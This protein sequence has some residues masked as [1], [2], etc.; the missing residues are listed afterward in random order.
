MMKLT[1]SLLATLA[2]AFAVPHAAHADDDDQPMQPDYD[3]ASPQ[4]ASPPT[5][6]PTEMPPVPPQ[7]L[8]P[9]PSAQDNAD[10]QD[11]GYEQPQQ[12]V[13]IEQAQSSGQWVYTA[14]YGWVW[15]PYGNQYVSAQSGDYDDAYSYV[16]YPGN[17]WIWLASP[18]IGGWGPWPYFGHYGYGHYGWWHRP[19]FAFHGGYGGYHGHFGNGYGRGGGHVGYG[20]VGGGVRVGGGV[21]RPS[22][23]G[24]HT[25]FATGQ[26]GVSRPSYS[27]PRSIGTV[28]GGASIS[29]SVGVSH[30]APVTHA[31]GGGSF[32]GGGGGGGHGGGGHGGRR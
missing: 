24:P 32:H 13:A 26:R 21:S 11:D 8:P 12:P 28:R 16:Y 27:G 20:H 9:P 23:S 3:S 22:Y 6:A 18:W 1:T 4:T 15:M 5:G 19:G 29:R 25:G 7:E 30:A 17:G 14:Q 2:L 10:V 31:G